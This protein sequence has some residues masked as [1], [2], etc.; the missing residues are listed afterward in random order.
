MQDIRTILL[1]GASGFIGSN[2]FAALV[3]QGYE[4]RALSRR[5]GHDFSQL[6]H[7]KDWRPHLA[8]VDAVINAV[9]IIAETA[10][11][12]FETLHHLAPTALFRACQSKGIRRVIQISAL[13]ADEQATTPYHLSK[14]AAD[15]ELRSLPLEWFVLRPSLVFGDGSRSLRLFQRLAGLPLIPLI[16]DGG[17]R[18]QPVH[19][20][21][22]VAVVLN[23]LKSNPPCLTLDLVG[24]REFRLRE[25]L[26]A[27]RARQGKSPTH[28]LAIP[29]SLVKA[30]FSLGRH[31]SPL[32]HPDNL[33]MLLRGNTADATPLADFLGRQPT[34]ME[35][36]P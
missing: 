21:D 31:F 8:G 11:Q 24:P 9:G 35:D 27:L 14:K 10:S 18:V 12:R 33:N 3:Q 13:G 20:D 29:I 7:P 28:T 19:I 5:T 2:L 26:L 22:L 25:W 16:G 6:I 15:D 30:G 23:T 4:V 36:W 34:A 1:T 32:L 17:Q